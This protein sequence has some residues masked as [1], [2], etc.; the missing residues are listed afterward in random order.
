MVTVLEICLRESHEQLQD[1]KGLQLSCKQ[2]LKEFWTFSKIFNL[3]TTTIC[4]CVQCTASCTVY[5]D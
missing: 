5:S 4:V 1:G 2:Q 3:S